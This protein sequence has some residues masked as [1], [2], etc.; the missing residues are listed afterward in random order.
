[1]CASSAT[2]RGL[3]VDREVV[4]RG[5]VVGD[6][7]HG[8]RPVAVGS[9]VRQRQA[10]HRGL[11]EHAQVV[12]VGERLRHVE[13]RSVART[14]GGRGVQ[15]AERLVH[16]RAALA[17][18]DLADDPLLVGARQVDP[19]LDD[20]ALA[21]RVLEHGMAHARGRGPAGVERGREALAHRVVIDHQAQRHELG[22][23]HSSSSVSSPVPSMVRPFITTVNPAISTRPR[24]AS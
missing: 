8:A 14:L 4:Q 18:I 16:A 12:V 2:G 19:V 6:R 23:D 7:A 20:A 1:L 10:R 5:E 17:A 11:D 15:A 9:E 21:R 22:I 3:D 24:A 13:S